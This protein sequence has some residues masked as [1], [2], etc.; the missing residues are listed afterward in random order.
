MTKNTHL[1]TGVALATAIIMPSDMRSLAV[2]ICGAAIGSTISDVDVA[3]SKPRKELNTIVGISV[4]AIAILIM[5]EVIFKIGIYQLIESQTGLYRT[6]L[7]FVTFL[8]L[9]IYG[10]TTKHRSYTHSV[11]GIMTFTGAICI[12]LPSMAL[13][14]C[15]GMISHVLLD[16]LNTKKV[17]VLYPYKKFGIALKLCHSDGKANMLIGIISTLVFVIELV[18]YALLKMHLISH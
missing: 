7:G 5:L 9:S 1:A 15:L 14:F 10:T 2:C 16:I 18:I 17:K 12:I 4:T 6:L 11:I 8:L 13:S 3:S